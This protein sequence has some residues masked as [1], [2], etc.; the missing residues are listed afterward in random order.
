MIME[1][2]FVQMPLERYDELIMENYRLNMELDSIV[3]IEADWNNEPT[4]RI[5]LSVLAARIRE[6]FE[7]SEFA[8]EWIMEDISNHKERV[9]GVF[10]QIEH[11]EDE[12]D[13]A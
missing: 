7:Q 6:K 10:K 3:K 12:E 8:G 2:G 4:L 1:K 9:W 13:Q 11:D 5:D